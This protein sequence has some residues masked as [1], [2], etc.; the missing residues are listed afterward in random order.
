MFLKDT[1]ILTKRVQFDSLPLA[2][3]TTNACT[4]APSVNGIFLIRLEL[5][6]IN[7]VCCYD[8]ATNQNDNDAGTAR[9]AIKPK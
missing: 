8:D 4:R 6:E 5:S 3:P 2:L 1:K 7:F 9:R